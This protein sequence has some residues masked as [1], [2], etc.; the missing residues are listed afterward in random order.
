MIVC[1]CPLSPQGDHPNSTKGRQRLMDNHTDMRR[2]ART[3]Q[4]RTSALLESLHTLAS[5]VTQLALTKDKDEA[6]EEVMS[7]AGDDAERDLVLYTK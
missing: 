5:A 2:A 4:A 1:G 3:L 7:I 6:P